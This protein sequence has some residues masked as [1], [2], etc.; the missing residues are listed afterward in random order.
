MV[1]RTPKRKACSSNLHGDVEKAAD[2]ARGLLLL[3]IHRSVQDGFAGQGVGDAEEGQ[4]DGHADVDTVVH[5]IEVGGAGVVIHV[6]LDLVDAGQRVEHRHIRRGQLQE[7]CV[8]GVAAFEPQIILF[9]E[10]ALLLD[11]GHVE[12]IKGRQLGF[13]VCGLLVRLMERRQ[14][15]VLDVLGNAQL[16][17]RDEHE[18]VPLKLAEGCGQ[19]VDRPAKFEVAAEADRQMIQP[20]F[21]LADGH[22]IDHG[23]GGVGMAAVARVD[24][25]DA[26]IHRGPERGAFFGVAHGDDVGI[27]ADDAGRVGHRLALAGARKLGPCKAQ[28]LAAEAEHGRLEGEAGAGAGFIEQRRKD[29]PVAQVRIGSG[30]RFH[31]VGKVE[32]GQ[33]LIQRKAVRLNE[34]SHSHSPFSTNFSRSAPVETN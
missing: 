28:R 27:V 10:E 20:P 9:V 11:A 25:G 7:L 21:A 15:L 14:C 23:L 8:Q 29:A 22:E 30:I 24:D 6:Q 34:V 1:R 26:S 31:P 17:R 33:L 32:K 13:E 19:G 3:C 16:L 4:N 18:L 2:P 12:D 5:L